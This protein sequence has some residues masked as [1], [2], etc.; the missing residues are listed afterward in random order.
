MRGFEDKPVNW[1][2]AS[3]WTDDDGA[4]QQTIEFIIP[5]EPISQG[6]II[7][8]KYG[9]LYDRTKGLRPWRE[10]V[11]CQARN[12]MAL[13]RNRAAVTTFEHSVGLH[14]AFVLPRPAS[15]P[16]HKYRPA[17]KKPDLDKLSRAISDSL[18]DAGVWRDDSQV[19]ELFATKRLADYGE[20]PGVHV[21]V[22][23]NVAPAKKQTAWIYPEEYPERC[24]S[25]E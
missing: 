21:L 20:K 22:T 9:N 8:G 11:T 13:A 23:S 4:I 15:Y 3:V 16:K 25:G 6:N 24:G 18:T 12:A 5:G 1:S 7:Q 19:V 10:M 2:P 14:I 17:I